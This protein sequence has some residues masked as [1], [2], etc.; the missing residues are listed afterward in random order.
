MGWILGSKQ[1]YS[2]FRT[3]G[4]LDFLFLGHFFGPPVFYLFGPMDS[5][6]GPSSY[7]IIFLLFDTSYFSLEG[8]PKKEITDIVLRQ[9]TML[10]VY[11]D[12]RLGAVHFN[13]WLCFLHIFARFC[14]NEEKWG[15]I[16]LAYFQML[17]FTKTLVSRGLNI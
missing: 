15:K 13:C 7:F 10:V 3:Y 1:Y 16:I 9:R 4:F 6:N 8:F 5:V 14:K 17:V 12:Q 11:F 2:F